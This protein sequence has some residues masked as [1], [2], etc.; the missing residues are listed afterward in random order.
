MDFY[1][2]IK[3]FEE[4]KKD[5][6]VINNSLYWNRTIVIAT[7]SKKTIF[8]PYS[9]KL[10]FSEISNEEYF[11]K[12]TMSELTKIKPHLK[13]QLLADYNKCFN[14]YNY[15]KLKEYCCY[16]CGSSHFKT[17]PDIKHNFIGKCNNCGKTKIELYKTAKFK[18]NIFNL[19]K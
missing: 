1:K 16:D 2:C 9:K 11:V 19:K 14:E 17:T 12:L 6:I 3:D 7:P 10:L 4:I 8:L 5:N 13:V 18:I 15:L